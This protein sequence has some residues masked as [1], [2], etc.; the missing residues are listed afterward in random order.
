MMDIQ[1]ATAAAFFVTGTGLGVSAKIIKKIIVKDKQDPD[2]NKPVLHT[3][4]IKPQ[5]TGPF[6]E[7]NWN[8]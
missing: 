6:T 5:P 7:V 2:E 3:Q 1:I 8:D 4:D